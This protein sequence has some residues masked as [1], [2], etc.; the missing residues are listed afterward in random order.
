MPARF[1]TTTSSIDTHVN[2]YNQPPCPPKQ[3]WEN[4]HF[5]LYVRQ[6]CIERFDQHCFGGKGVLLCLMRKKN[7]KILSTT[8]DLILVRFFVQKRPKKII[9]SRKLVSFKLKYAIPALKMSR[10]GSVAH[11]HGSWTTYRAQIRFHFGTTA[12]V[13]IQTNEKHFCVMCILFFS[14][15]TEQMID[16][17]NWN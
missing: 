14:Y 7:E 3:C 15:D 16:A 10:S 12:L 11:R 6:L 4:A 13:P 9:S 2:V 8:V 17:K 5:S 1:L